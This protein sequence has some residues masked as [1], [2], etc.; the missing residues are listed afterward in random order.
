M[1]KC[2]WK[3]LTSSFLQDL[4]VFKTFVF[5]VALRHWT[6]SIA[7]TYVPTKL[8]WQNIS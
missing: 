8:F 6:F 4:S 3:I 1:I 5:T 7:K 2:A